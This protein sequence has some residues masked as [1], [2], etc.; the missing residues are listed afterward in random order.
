MSMGFAPNKTPNGHKYF[1]S[2]FT[3]LHR[4][5]GFRFSKPRQKSEDFKRKNGIKTMNKEE[6]KT[7]DKRD[8]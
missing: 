5:S 6:S 7:Q 3:K 8:V 4:L 1:N 2:H